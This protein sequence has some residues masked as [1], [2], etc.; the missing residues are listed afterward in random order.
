MRK[1]TAIYND[2]IS[3]GYYPGSSLLSLMIAIHVKAE[4]DPSSILDLYR[5]L[6]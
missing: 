2:C 3:E 4:Q 5:T 1:I 6:R